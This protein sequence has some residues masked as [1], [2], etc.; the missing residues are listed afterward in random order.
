MDRQENQQAYGS[1]LSDEVIDDMT[2]QY[3]D[4]LEAAIDDNSYTS[5]EEQNVYTDK[6]KYIT[7]VNSVDEFFE[8]VCYQLKDHRTV[9]YYDTDVELLY[10]NA[11]YIFDGIKNYYYKTNPMISSGYYN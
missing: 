1:K 8:E 9:E 7:Y 2:R 10:N 5:L 11:D 6:D 4:G 3:I